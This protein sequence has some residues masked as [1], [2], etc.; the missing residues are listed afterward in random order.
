[1]MLLTM[2]MTIVADVIVTMIFFFIFIKTLMTVTSHVVTSGLMR[3]ASAAVS[4]RTWR[5]F[6]SSYRGGAMPVMV[7]DD[8]G[9]QC[10]TKRWQHER[11]R[12]RARQAVKNCAI[13]GITTCCKRAHTPLQRIR[14]R[15]KR[16][17][18]DVRTP[19]Q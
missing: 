10:Y 6:L 5:A 2:M 8:L 16:R 11:P 3:P 17:T 18:A 9:V 19:Q 7:R 12:E 14:L 4:P 15:C 1:M 13:R